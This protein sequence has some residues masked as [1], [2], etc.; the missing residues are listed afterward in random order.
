TKEACSRFAKLKKEAV[1]PPAAA[2]SAS[3]ATPTPRKRKP[4]PKN[5]ASADDDDD[6][7]DYTPITKRSKVKR[8]A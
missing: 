6:K 8:E 5:A 3:T 2:A 7:D 1:D 4:K